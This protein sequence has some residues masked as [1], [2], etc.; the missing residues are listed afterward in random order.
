VIVDLEDAVAPAAKEEARAN[1]EDLL[2]Q[3]REKPV[4][5]RVNPGS[6]ADLEAVAHLEK[7]CPGFVAEELACKHSVTTKEPSCDA[8][9]GYSKDKEDP[10]L[11]LAESHCILATDC[12]SLA[13]QGICGRAQA[14]RAQR[15]GTSYYEEEGEPQSAE[16]TYSTPHPKVCP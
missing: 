4:F 1:L 15:S 9:G 8:T 16:K 2:G 5:V 14:A 10:A 6:A 3:R 7:C 11:D 12:D 13:R